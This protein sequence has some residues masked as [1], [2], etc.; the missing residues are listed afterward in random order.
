MEIHGRGTHLEVCKVSV[1]M[2]LDRQQKYCSL[3]IKGNRVRVIN[4]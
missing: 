1:W 2:I 3:M 4:K